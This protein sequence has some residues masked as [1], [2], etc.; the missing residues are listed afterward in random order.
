MLSEHLGDGF[1]LASREPGGGTPVGEVRASLGWDGGFG[2]LVNFL[3]FILPGAFATNCS[4]LFF[5]FLPFLCLSGINLIRALAFND[6][7]RFLD[8]EHSSGDQRK[9]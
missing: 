6:A 4:H 1:E 8:T 5:F 7:G 3:I 2:L 9:A